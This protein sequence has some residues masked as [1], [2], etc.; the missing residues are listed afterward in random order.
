M[1]TIEKAAFVLFL[2]DKDSQVSLVIH[3]YCHDAL[4]FACNVA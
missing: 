4:Y 3:C 1:D 2:D